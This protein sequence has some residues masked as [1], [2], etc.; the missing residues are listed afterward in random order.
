MPTL[1]PSRKVRYTA[2]DVNAI[3]GAI[4]LLEFM[5]DFDKTFAAG[6]LATAIG[7]LRLA[8]KHINAQ[9]NGKPAPTGNTAS[10]NAVKAQVAANAAGKPADAK[11]E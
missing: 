4:T 6:E 11:P 8:A 10:S 1:S 3:A 2:P 9:R 7:G 5:G